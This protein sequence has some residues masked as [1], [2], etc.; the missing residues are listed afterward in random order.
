MTQG[1]AGQAA[2]DTE[3][4]DSSRSDVA[5]AGAAAAAA[6]PQR[7]HRDIMMIMS[8]PGP[9]PSGAPGRLGRPGSVHLQSGPHGHSDTE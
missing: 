4:Q 9:W 8:E 1:R 7:R 3:L 5:A 6:P 2:S